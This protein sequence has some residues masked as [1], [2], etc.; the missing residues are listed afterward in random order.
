M[1]WQLKPD[2]TFKLFE[3]NFKKML[4]S[5]VK[6]GVINNMKANNIQNKNTT[7]KFFSTP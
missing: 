2:G 7:H 5:R 3:L 4:E 6:F 1:V